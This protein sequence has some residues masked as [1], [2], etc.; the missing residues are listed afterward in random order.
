MLSRK[1][2]STSIVGL[3]LDVGSIAAAEIELNGRAELTR[4]AISPLE[5][6][7]FSDGE[8]AD[9][10]TVS[11]ALKAFFSEHDLAKDVRIGVA[12]QRVVFRTLR[13]PAIED[14]A[15][16][17]A[18]VRFQAQEEIPMP[19][20]SAVLEYQ[21]IGG[22][23]GPD[24]NAQ[25]D[26]AIVAA[27]REMV[28]RFIEPVRKAGLRPV[29]ID[30]AAFGMIRALAS[31]ETPAG[32][33]EGGEFVP[34]V[35]YCALGDATN[36]AIARRFACLFART[37]Q[38]GVA[39]LSRRLSEKTGLTD[40]HARQWLLHVGLSQSPEEIE[41]DADTVRHTREILERASDALA[42]ELRVSL[43]YYGAQEDAVPVGPVVLSGEGSAIP[44]L[45]E[46]VADALRREVRVAR[47]AALSGLE[48]VQS[49]RLTVP[50]GL[51]LE[52]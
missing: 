42:D 24:G 3:D 44:G 40:Q 18:A 46:R 23:N 52:R 22:V 31:S 14:P 16:M 41:G 38:F 2:K 5:P 34:A 30:L 12:N 45:A 19:L 27:R 35:L 9:L 11:D 7:A 33:G 39:Q 29:G 50:Y 49:A 20:E 10:D 1:K 13:L 25:V 15:E 51:A 6:G 48:D 43:D 26:V 8:V 21:V 17:G 47:P 28:E 32:E 36:L 37:S 4:T